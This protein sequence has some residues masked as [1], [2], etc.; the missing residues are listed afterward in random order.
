VFFLL[1]FGSVASENVGFGLGPNVHKNAP[2]AIAVASLFFGMFYMLVTTAFVA[3]VVIRDD[4]TGYGP[5]VRSTRVRKFDY[6]FG[7]FIGAFGAVLVSFLAVPLGMMAGTLAPWVD[8]ETLGPF[9]FGDY[10][11]NY[12]VFARPRCCSPRPCSSRWPR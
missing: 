4:S 11:Y 2:V 3:N 5:I 10:A 8:P 7:R 6:L 12:A 9:R 1:S